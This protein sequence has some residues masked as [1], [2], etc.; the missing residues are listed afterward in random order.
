MEY[1]YVVHSSKWSNEAICD[2]LESAIEIATEV[3]DP[4]VW[5]SFYEITKRKVNKLE[6]GK[7]HSF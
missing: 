3:H 7:R 4:S 5:L 2:N 6:G 1:V